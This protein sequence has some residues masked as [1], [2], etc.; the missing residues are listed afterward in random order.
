LTWYRRNSNTLFLIP[1]GLF[2]ISMV[3]LMAL[4]PFYDN[5]DGELKKVYWNTFLGLI[6]STFTS[7]CILMMMEVGSWEDVI[8]TTYYNFK[9]LVLDADDRISDEF[10]T[11][12][13]YWK[14]RMIT[15]SR[16]KW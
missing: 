8:T 1:L 3:Y 13:E 15:G 6:F 7:F 9:P 16:S 14:S 11:F 2:V 5:A 10:P 12:N 4:M